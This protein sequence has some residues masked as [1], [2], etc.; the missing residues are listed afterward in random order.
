MAELM[1]SEMAS[2]RRLYDMPR[3][4]RK[5]S[6]ASGSLVRY[7]A[8]RS[9]TGFVMSFGLS[10]NQIAG[11]PCRRTSDCIFRRILKRFSLDIGCRKPYKERLLKSSFTP[12]SLVFPEFSNSILAAANLS[13]ESDRTMRSILRKSF[14]LT[15]NML[16]RRFLDRTLMLNT[17]NAKM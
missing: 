2:R 1:G 9:F 12:S 8:S 3:L 14:L 15:L 7:A 6:A 11:T 16:T 17:R 13:A 10:V 5:A 4:F